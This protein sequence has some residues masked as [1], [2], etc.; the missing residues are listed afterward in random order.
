MIDLVIED[1]DGLLCVGGRF[2]YPDDWYVAGQASKAPASERL[3]VER[4]LIEGYL[5][6]NKPVLG[7]CAGM[8][9]LGC[10]KGCRLWS[11]IQASSPGALTHDKAGHLHSIRVTPNTML[12]ALVGEESMLVNSFHREAIAEVS[13]DVVASAHSAD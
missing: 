13:P 4:R 5:R 11:D 3:A 12:A 7:I 2:A 1:F 6:L 9:L 8:Q 10:V